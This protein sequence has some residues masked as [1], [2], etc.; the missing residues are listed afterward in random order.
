V[1]IDTELSR[2]DHGLIPVTTIERGLKLLVVRTNPRT[3]FNWWWKQKKKEI[4][5]FNEPKKNSCSLNHNKVNYIALTVI[6]WQYFD[7]NYEKWERYIDQH[8][9]VV[10][11]CLEDDIIV[12]FDK[13]LTSI[14]VGWKITYYKTPNHTT[15]S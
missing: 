10:A 14:F 5:K 3:K 1:G 12:P 6:W 4:L 7:G 13:L 8:R 15:L 2:G 11:I 9:N